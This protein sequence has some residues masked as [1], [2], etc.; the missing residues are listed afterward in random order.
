MAAE[1]KLDTRRVPR[2][3]LSK[4]LILSAISTT[5]FHPAAF[6]GAG[7]Q[8]EDVERNEPRGQESKR[9]RGACDVIVHQAD[10]PFS[11]RI[12][13]MASKHYMV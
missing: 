2:K 8:M 13:R 1:C 11:V 12:G 4:L 3:S 10:L 7:M 5:N 6:G 9:E